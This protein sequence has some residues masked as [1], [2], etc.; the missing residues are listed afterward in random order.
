MKMC[1]SEIII[2]YHLRIRGR[3]GGGLKERGGLTNFLPP[4]GGGRLF[5]EV[6]LEGGF[7]FFFI[8]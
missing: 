8:L 4:E 3:G 7:T 6:G 2:V 1:Y 5:R